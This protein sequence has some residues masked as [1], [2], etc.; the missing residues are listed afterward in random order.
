VQKNITEDDGN[1][2]VAVM[3]SNP[4]LLAALDELKSLLSIK[5]E[6]KDLK[7]SILE[8]IDTL[9]EEVALRTQSIKNL[10]KQL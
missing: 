9:E 5:D 1:R 10:M 2:K 7:A 3:E 8:Q 6:K 4:V